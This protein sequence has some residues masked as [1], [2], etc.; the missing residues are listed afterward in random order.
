MHAR[1]FLLLWF[2]EKVYNYFVRQTAKIP[3]LL[4]KPFTIWGM[5]RSLSIQFSTQYLHCSLSKIVRHEESN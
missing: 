1:D 4:F 5:L 2:N 3:V